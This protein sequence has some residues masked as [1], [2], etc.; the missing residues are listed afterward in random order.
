MRPRCECF[1]IRQRNRSPEHVTILLEPL[2]SSGA[3]GCRQCRLNRG[4]GNVSPQAQMEHGTG[5]REGSW[6]VDYVDQR[7]KRHLKTFE[8]KKE[9][10]AYEATVSIEVRLGT[11][12]ADSQSLTI[13]DA[14]RKWLATAD[15]TGL[16]RTTQDQY[17]QHLDLHIA[18]LVG[19]IR[20]SQLS[21]PLV[22]EF[23]SGCG[24]T[25]ARRR[26]S[27]RSSEVWSLVA[28]RWTRSRF[29]QSGSRNEGPPE[30]RQGKAGG[31]KAE[32]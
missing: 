22:R 26:W 12:T 27:A 8:R 32:G 20:L 4:T 24:R 25:A 21:V 9:A 13:E 18:P 15:E 6:V 29:A 11:H 10:D 23:E 30:A 14:G 1:H 31:R 17:R 16:E 5:G 7:G 19:A 2:P 3:A 28:E